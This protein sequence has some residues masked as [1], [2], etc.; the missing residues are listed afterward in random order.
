MGNT[1]QDKDQR[2]ISGIPYC[3]SDT[4]LAIYCLSNY[5][6]WPVWVAE[7]RLIF[8]VHTPLERWVRGTQGGNSAPGVH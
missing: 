1:R 6:F 4:L 3:E 5:S 2:L 7:M 8:R